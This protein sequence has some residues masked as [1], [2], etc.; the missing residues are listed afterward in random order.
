MFLIC[1][2]MK[3]HKIAVQANLQFLLQHLN[4][5]SFFLHTTL[6]QFH[7][8]IA[9]MCRNGKSLRA[10]ELCDKKKL[11][12]FY[13]LTLR[14]YVS[15][16]LFFLFYDAYIKLSKILF[17]PYFCYFASSYH[18]CYYYHC[19]MCM[20]N[21]EHSFVNKKK[22]FHGKKERKKK[23]KYL[24]LPRVEVAVEGI[25]IFYI[26]DFCSKIE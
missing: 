11:F 9:K 24:W 4:K 2:I 20:W 3:R 8:K 7:I 22:F 25:N 16:V 19:V 18:Y 6:N 13:L 23:Q 15:H 1:S 5:I 14:Y 26:D 10:S 21:I 17:L 12:I